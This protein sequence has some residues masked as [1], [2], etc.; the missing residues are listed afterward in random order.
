VVDEIRVKVKSRPTLH[1]AEND[2]APALGRGEGKR[3]LAGHSFIRE[4][5]RIAL[6][7][8]RRCKRENQQCTS[9]FEVDHQ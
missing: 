2:G 3:I 5:L 7:C 6:G 4:P 1:A 8:V 9:E